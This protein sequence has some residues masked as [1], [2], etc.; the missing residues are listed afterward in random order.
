MRRC[1]ITGGAG[2]IGAN[3]VYYCLQHYPQQPI[4]ILD[5]LT[6]AANRDY[7]S[8][9]EQTGYVHFIEGNIC[10]QGLV[11][12]LLKQFSINTIVNFA[13]E[14]HVDRSI[15]N[16]GLFVETNIQGTQSLLNA[17]KTVWQ[18]E[19]HRFHQVSTDE[20]Y[21]SLQEGQAAFTEQH[22]FQPNSPYAASKA[23][24][25]HLV[26]AYHHTYG[27]NTTISHCSNNYGRFQA[28]EKLLPKCIDR[29]VQGQAIPVYGDGRNIRDWL[30][31]DDHCRAID[32][33]LQHGVSGERY[34]I[35]ANCEKRNIDLITQ[36]C[37]MISQRYPELT[38]KWPHGAESMIEFV[39]DRAGHDWRYAIDAHKIARDCGFTATTDFVTG[40]Q[41]TIEWYLKGVNHVS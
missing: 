7:L 28:K 14:T 19:Q 13:A 1:L 41:H 34:N 18:T 37:Q 35:G 31:V 21:G 38:A 12:Q 39:S 16:P 32:A 20:V 8:A 40:L 24:A 29:L 11:T 36:V 10:D 25:D 15:E 22:C 5:A 27:L 6:Y 26:H 33:I 17:A 23:G 4:V 3:F 30:Y 9:A 2:F